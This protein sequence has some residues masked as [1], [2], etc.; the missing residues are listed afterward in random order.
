ML[1]GFTPWQK[2]TTLL[3]TAGTIVAFVG[4]IGPWLPVIVGGFSLAICGLFGLLLISSR[5]NMRAL[6]SVPAN[7]EKTHQPRSRNK[8]AESQAQVP[9]IGS[10]YE[11]ANRIL[12][13]VAGYEAFALRSR[14]HRIRDS[15]ALAATNKTFSSEELMQFVAVQRMEMMPSLKRSDFREWSPKAFLA[16]ARLLANQ[17][18]RE[19]DLENAVRLFSFAEAFF[20]TKILSRNDRLINLEILGELQRFEQQE[21]LA[22]RFS[23]NKQDPVQYSLIQLNSIQATNEATSA[24]TLFLST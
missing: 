11:Y 20:G 1:R 12:R 15:F 17:R 5:R 16:L 6:I 3:G 4:V 21:G 2:R 24:H 18:T 8:L 22:G 19:D 13:N 10:P 14:S 23:L 7:Y 9:L